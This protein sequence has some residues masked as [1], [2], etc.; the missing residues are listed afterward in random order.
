[1]ISSARKNKD[2]WKEVSGVRERIRQA[3]NRLREERWLLGLAFKEN[4]PYMAG[5]IL[6]S[7]GLRLL[8]YAVEYWVTGSIRV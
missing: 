5:V 8:L 1:M 4:L 7:V 6:G 3:R 2:N